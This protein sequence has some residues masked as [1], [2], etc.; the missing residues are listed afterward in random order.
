[1]N[2]DMIS[3]DISEVPNETAQ[4]AI[5]ML[6]HIAIQLHKATEDDLTMKVETT[7]G[8]VIEIAIREVGGDGQ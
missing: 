3:M 2:N 5:K 8:K 4:A 6:V 1:M 7:D